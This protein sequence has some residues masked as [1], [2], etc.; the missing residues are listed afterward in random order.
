MYRKRSFATGG[1]RAEAVVDREGKRTRAGDL[2]QRCGEGG[3]AVN[4]AP[5]SPAADL[6]SWGLALAA[7]GESPASH[8]DERGALWTRHDD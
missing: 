1:Q 4:T 2:G 3:R 6:G 7:R 5:W 8:R